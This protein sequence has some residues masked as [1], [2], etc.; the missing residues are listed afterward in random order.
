MVFIKGGFSRP[1][2]VGS[3]I[4]TDDKGKK[5]FML[6]QSYMPAQDI[7]IVRNPMDEE[8]SPWYEVSRCQ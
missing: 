1:R 4:A 8:L 5:Y 2:Y 3:D 7:H 6:A